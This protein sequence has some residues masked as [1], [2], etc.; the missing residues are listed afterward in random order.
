MNDT[1]KV[2]NGKQTLTFG[3]Q[4]MKYLAVDLGHSAGA[5]N[6]VFAVMI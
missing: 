5:L 1:G 3:R 4:R 6:D 2:Y